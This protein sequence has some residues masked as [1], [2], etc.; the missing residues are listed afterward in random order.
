MRRP[1]AVEQTL[2]V[3]DPLRQFLTLLAEAVRHGEVRSLAELTERMHQ[4]TWEFGAAAVGTLMQMAAEGAPTEQRCGCGAEAHSDGFRERE[5]VVRFGPATVQRRW[6]VCRRCGHGWAPFDEAFGLPVGRYADDVKE[7]AVKLA[8]DLPDAQACEHLRKLWR[9]AP[10]PHTVERWANAAGEQLIETQRTE[11]E[12]YWQS[13]GEP[14]GAAVAQPG[15]GVIEADG[16]QVLTWKPGQHPRQRAP[17]T[18][19]QPGQQSGRRSRRTP[20]V[21]SEVEG[22]PHGPPERSKRTAGREVRVGLSYP[23]EA[24]AQLSATRATLTTVRYVARLGDADQFWRQMHLGAHRVGALGRQKLLNVGDGAPWVHEQA[25]DCFVAESLEDILDHAHA[26]Q[27]LWDAGHTLYGKGPR[28]TAWAQQ[29]TDQIDEGQAAQVVEQLMHQRSL[30]RSKSKAEALDSL[31]GYIEP[32]INQ[33]DYPRYRANGW[34][35]GSGAVES[36]TKR[37][38]G[39]RMK[40]GGMIWGVAGATRRAALCAAR[41]NTGDWDAIARVPSRQWRRITAEA[42]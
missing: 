7:A 35:Q 33:M 17:A 13:L 40:Q 12:A 42:A 24:V 30:Q 9:Q 1:K 6:M 23:S 21:L 14:K 34:P 4:G 41:Y 26:V 15:F 32:R 22:S 2:E 36:A 25:R 39:R 18:A 20:S 19:P 8:C 38:I 5:V 3:L 10:D 16:T 31:V 29:R 27:H 37:V 28:L 11:A